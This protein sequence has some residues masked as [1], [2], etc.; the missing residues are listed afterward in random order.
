[1]MQVMMYSLGFYLDVN[2]EMSES[3]FILL[4]WVS[5]LISA[6]V[7]F[8]C[9][10]PFYLS[11][12][13]ALKNATVNMDVPVTIAIFS[14]WTASLFTTLNGQGEVYFD[15]VSM[16]V[17][18]LL[19]GRYLQM[20]AVHKTGRVLEERLKSKPETAMLLSE[21]KTNRVLLEDVCVGD[22][23][24][25]K[26]GQQIPC[27]AVI[28]TGETSIDNAFLTGEAIPMHQVVGDKVAAG[29][30]NRGDVI[31]IE[32]L[33]PANESTLA[34]IINLL[35]KA[36]TSKP[37][38]QLIADKVASY[39]VVSVLLLATLTAIYWYFIDSTQLLS[40]VLAVLVV[41]CPCALSL[42]TPVAITAGLGKLSEQSLLLNKTSA[43]VSLS[44][45]TDIVFD[46][47]GT[48]TTGR[49]SI[50]SLCN[51][52]DLSNENILQIIHSIE[53]GSEHPVATAFQNIAEVDDG[54]E[55][56]LLAEKLCIIPSRGLTATINGKVW[57]FGNEA[58]LNDSHFSVEIPN[59]EVGQLVLFLL[60]DKGCQARVL[61]ETEVR[62]DALKTVEGLKKRG[63]TVHLLSGDREDNVRQLA[64]EL[65]FKYFKAEQTPIQKLDYIKQLQDS[66]KK[67][68]MIG[69]GIN[70][71]PAMAASL[72]SFAIA[73]STDITKVNSDIIMLGEKL[74]IV[75]DAIDTSV[76]VRKIIKQN[77][78][79]AL[80]Y[81][82]LGLPLAVSGLLS[83]WLAAIGMSLSS[84][85]VV[86]NAM[87]LT[88]KKV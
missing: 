59:I 28:T 17:F 19:S 3:T 57:Q 84:L 77:L 83:P 24:V 66:G 48:L 9:A 60:D 47:T 18:F 69:D 52:S 34:G 26:P 15:S 44:E 74:S 29:A 62:V 80:T 31:N 38:I 68:A 23:L 41:T 14:A 88:R 40:T 86:L 2:Q 35:Q 12:G 81:N 76:A 55:N 21:G 39:F 51:Y 49:F 11:A 82:S 78:F 20:I 42:A 30:I 32:V 87:R 45:L 8:Y 63:L 6:P 61:I 5:L 43:L 16:F 36:Q 27:D 64:K 22:I 71:S 7:V 79:W 4:R 50:V 58:L 46:K 67:A 75:N 37:S 85:V 53:S 72:V 10:S 70:D 56:S 73:K 13:K 1:M 33:S 65:D 25:V 54:K